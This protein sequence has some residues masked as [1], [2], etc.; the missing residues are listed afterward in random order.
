MGYLYAKKFQHP[1][2]DLT[3][4]IR[5]EIYPEPYESIYWPSCRNKVAQSD[6]YSPHTKLLDTLYLVL[7][8][9]EKYACPAFVRRKGMEF[10]YKQVVMDDENTNCQVCLGKVAAGCMLADVK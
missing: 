4:S 6:L 8:A 10:A 2:D 9:W 3:R 7:G 5:A 1:L